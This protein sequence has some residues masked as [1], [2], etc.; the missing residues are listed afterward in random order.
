MKRKNAAVVLFLCAVLTL[1][2]FFLAF[3]AE[4]HCIG[5]DC[6]VCCLIGLLEKRLCF[7]QTN[8][9]LLFASSVFAVVLLS[10]CRPF[11]TRHNGSLVEAHT[12]FSE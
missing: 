5:K 2:L 10:L 6:P 9:V 8:G 4:H 7:L 1:S 3:G 11:F 12:K